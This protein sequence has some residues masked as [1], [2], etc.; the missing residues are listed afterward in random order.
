[1]LLPGHYLDLDIYSRIDLE[2]GNI[3]STASTSQTPHSYL[4]SVYYATLSILS[5][6]GDND[7]SLKLH[8]FFL[9]RLFFRSCS[10]MGLDPTSVE[11]EEVRR[12]VNIFLRHQ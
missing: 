3:H 4:V 11:Y 6:C 9:T 5:Q 7:S 12:D 2:Q 10:A 8:D 1:M